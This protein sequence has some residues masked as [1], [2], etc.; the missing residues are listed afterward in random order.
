MRN[1]ISK[2]IYGIP[3]SEVVRIMRLK[4]KEGITSA[5]LECK[6]LG[7]RTLCQKLQQRMK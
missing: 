4:D 5:I 7:Y 3:Y 1:I 2:L 6:F